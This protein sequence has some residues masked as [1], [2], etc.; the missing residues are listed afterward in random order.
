MGPSIEL[1]IFGTA[2][3]TEEGMRHAATKSMLR[4]IE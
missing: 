3:T 2:V 4:I 1:D